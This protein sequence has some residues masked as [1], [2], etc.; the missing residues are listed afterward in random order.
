MYHYFHQCLSTAI[1]ISL[2]I[3]T[4]NPLLAACPEIYS[5]KFSDRGKTRKIT[6][7]IGNG[8]KLTCQQKYIK[9]QPKY[10]YRYDV[11]VACQNNVNIYSNMDGEESV[12]IEINGKAS[13]YKSEFL[14]DKYQCTS[15][16]QTMI[17]RW[18]YRNGRNVIRETSYD[19]SPYR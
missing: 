10:K 14:G 17:K 1:I 7:N 11:L 2:T 19:Y 4:A 16:G 12:T 18:V 3:V 15:K 6:V 8:K 9:P 5:D 13:E